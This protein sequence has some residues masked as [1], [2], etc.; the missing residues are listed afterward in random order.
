MHHICVCLLLQN[1]CFGPCRKGHARAIRAW[2]FS[3]SFGSQTVPRLR[4][5][6]GFKFGILLL[7]Y[8]QGGKKFIFPRFR[9]IALERKHFHCVVMIANTCEPHPVQ[10]SPFLSLV[11]LPSLPLSVTNQ[12]EP[13]Q[14][15]VFPSQSWQGSLCN[16]LITS[17]SSG[18]PKEQSVMGL[19]VQWLREA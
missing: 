14:N 10:L 18:F 1:K 7:L 9:L 19:G 17:S 5:E 4:G 16:G 6:K 11:C 15:L 8:I 2:T 13:K 3:K 12:K